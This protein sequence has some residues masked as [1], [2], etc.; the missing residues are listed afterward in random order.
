MADSWI[1]DITHYLDDSGNIVPDYGSVFRFAEYL[2]SIISLITHPAPVPVSFDVPC[3]RRPNR[4]PCNGFIEG[5]ADPDTDAIVWWCPECGDHGF[6]SN[7]QGTIWDLSD[8]G[9][10]V[11]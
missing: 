10:T 4:K 2:V 1:T 9:D 5:V 8:A 7:W 6:I 3:R 11:H